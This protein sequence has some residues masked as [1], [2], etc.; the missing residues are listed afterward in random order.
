MQIGAM[1]HPAADVL[2]EIL[3]MSEMDLDFIDLTIEPPGAASWRIN[4]SEVRRELERRNMNV[5]GH[6]AFYLPFASAFDGVRKAA[7]EEL[8][9]C[10]ELFAEVG[11]KCMNLHPDRHAPMHDRRFYIRRNLESL[12]ELQEYGDRVGVG[13]MIEN[14]PGDFNDAAQLGELLDPMPKLGLHLDIGHANLMV[15]YNTTEQIL[16]AHGARLRHTHLHDNKGG[17]ADLHLPLGA[18]NLDL[19]RALLALQ[20][21]EFDGTITLEVFTP[22]RH[23][24]AYSRD[25]LRKAWDDIRAEIGLSQSLLGV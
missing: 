17:H 10:L 25:I 9:R 7:V 4:A 8:R 3:W 19:R 20:K 24:L 11:A 22:D 18:G 15:P 21:C 23:Y 5:V 13:L 16:E 2:S 6:T 1:N 12:T 14:L